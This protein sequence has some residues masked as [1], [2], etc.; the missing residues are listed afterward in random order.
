MAKYI[1]K[2]VLMAL[3]TVLLVACITFVLMN[4][5]PGGPFL[6]EKTP[7]PAVIAKLNETYGLDKPLPTQLAMYLKKAVT[8]DFGVS[9]KMQKDRPVL[10][11][12]K[13]M[14]PISAKIGVI[15]ILGAILLGIPLGCLA[16]YNRGNA[17]DG[18]FSVLMTIGIAIPGFVLSTI[19]LVSFAGGVWKIFPSGGLKGW[20]S[21]VLPC[22][23]LGFN[24][25][26][27]VAR[28]T[29]SSM[30][31]AINQEYIKTARVKGLKTPVILFKHALRNALIP[32][33]TYIGPMT[34]S[35][36]TGG[37]VVETVFN[38]PG[39]GRYFIQSI[40]GRDYPLIM[41][42]TIFLASFVILMNLVV[43]ILYHVVDPRIDIT[44]GGN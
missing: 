5:I 23:A 27:Y 22:F 2:R 28:L 13:E 24:P 9:L 32:V 4:M 15:A 31:D 26:C 3:A 34:A 33:I 12:I 35:V 6:S 37:F 18:I 1:S 44:R 21:Y 25:M 40:N 19:L 39:L 41:G 10:T 36:L 29:R 42:T 43:D 17:I 7:S 16:A 38:I 20:T 30:L 14:F 11:I 8:G